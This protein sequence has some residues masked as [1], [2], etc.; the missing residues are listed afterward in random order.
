MPPG[1]KWPGQPSPWSKNR[2]PKA[3]PRRVPKGRVATLKRAVR[4]RKRNHLCINRDRN[5]C[6]ETLLDRRRWKY[7]DYQGQPVL[8]KRRRTWDRGK[9]QFPRSKPPIRAREAEYN[10]VRRLGLTP[11]LRSRQQSLREFSKWFRKYGV[12]DSISNALVGTLIRA[13]FVPLDIGNIVAT[14]SKGWILVIR[15]PTYRESKRLLDFCSVTINTLL[16][17]RFQKRME[18]L[19]LLTDLD[20]RRLHHDF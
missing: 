9:V 8:S 17:L 16:C 2:R 6:H 5:P 18:R 4:V 14:H 13:P 15:K 1:W 11:Q 19:R 10:E 20:Y 3:P 7:V 12:I